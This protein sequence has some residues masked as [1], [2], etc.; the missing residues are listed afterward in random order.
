MHVS[1]Q[2]QSLKLKND[3]LIFHVHCYDHSLNLVI[4]SATESCEVAKYFLGL[5]NTMTVFNSESDKRMLV[6]TNINKKY[7]EQHFTLWTLK[8]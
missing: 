1:Q 7:W 2:I 6:W 3:N 5:L 8:D 4:F